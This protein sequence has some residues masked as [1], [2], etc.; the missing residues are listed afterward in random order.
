MKI[1]AFFPVLLTLL[2]ALIVAQTRAATVSW[3]G[4]SGDWNTPSNWSGAALPG[5]DD[6]VVIDQP[7]NITVTHLSGDHTVKSV[8]SEER[9]VLSG[10]S[11]TVSG[12]LQVN[13]T[14]ALSGG[15]LVHAT[16]L[17]GANGGGSRLVVQY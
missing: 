7:A 6:D 4:G 13:N 5:P 11:V 15:T 17:K 12:T 14:F 8:R 16:V 1:P 2:T 10:G 9:F 3:T